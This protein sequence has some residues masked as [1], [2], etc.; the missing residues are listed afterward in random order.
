LNQ[1]QISELINT[2][3]TRKS[4]SIIRITP[5]RPWYDVGLRELY[6]SRELLLIFTWRLIS[7]QFRHAVLGIGWI[8]FTPLLNT[9]MFTI[10]F[11]RLAQLPSD[12]VPYPLFV[13]SGMVGWQYFAR[14]M[15]VGSSSL[16]T[17]AN[18]VSKVYFPRLILPVSAV[19]AGVLEF[20]VN[21]CACLIVLGFYG[22]F[23]GITV[24]M[25]PIFFVPL[26]ALGLA[27]CFWTSSLNVFYRDVLILLPIGLQ[28]LML[29]TPIAYSTSVIPQN[30]RWLLYLNPLAPLIQGI[31]WSLL[32]Q[33][34]PPTVLSFALSLCFT[35]LIFCLG[36]VFFR[37]AEAAFADRI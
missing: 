9:L 17:N 24:F 14:V 15:A 4:S 26:M 12:G 7:V 37:K 36:L 29:L 23:P 33:T 27:I 31:R 1:T 32:P 10:V 28:A 16:Q 6:A 20:A 2:A 22:Q 35:V 21:L 34:E 11:G 3:M 8:L 19:L 18:I 5:S 30:F 25:I 13:F